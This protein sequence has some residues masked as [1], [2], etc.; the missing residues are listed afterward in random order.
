MHLFLIN[1]FA[2]I[3]NPSRVFEENELDAI[4]SAVMD[5]KS[6]GIKKMLAILESTKR[7]SNDKQVK[8]H[9]LTH[10]ITQTTSL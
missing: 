10:L 1:L 4:I 6:I 3:F 8:L 2:L 9:R 7:T 5:G